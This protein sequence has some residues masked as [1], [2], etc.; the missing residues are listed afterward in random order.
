[1]FTARYAL[2]PYIKQICFFFKYTWILMGIISFVFSSLTSFFLSRLPFI[3][4]ALSLSLSLFI[5]N[6][7]MQYVKTVYPTDGTVSRTDLSPLYLT[8]TCFHG[9][10]VTT[11]YRHA[12]YIRDESLTM[13]HFINSCMHKCSVSLNVILSAIWNSAAHFH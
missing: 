11:I 1:V 3:S 12:S 2:S 8:T 9:E 7:G 4:L 10:G 13:C 5:P 6:W